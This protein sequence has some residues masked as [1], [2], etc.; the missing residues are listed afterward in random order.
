MRETVEFLDNARIIKKESAE[1]TCL[2]HVH[3]DALDIIVIDS[4][5]KESFFF[6]TPPK[7]TAFLNINKT[8]IREAAPSAL[9]IIE[10]N[11]EKLKLFKTDIARFIS[12]PQSLDDDTTRTYRA[13]KRANRIHKKR[14]HRHP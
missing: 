12:Q 2:T 10:L 7:A 13:R 1:K 9:E 3:P 6:H 5:P 4:P 8:H 14:K 11:A